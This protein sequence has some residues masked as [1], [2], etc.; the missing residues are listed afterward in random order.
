MC[1]TNILTNCSRKIVGFEYY[2]T[3]NLYL[4][5][6]AEQYNQIL[7]NISEKKNDPDKFA[8]QGTKRKAKNNLYRGVNFVNQAHLE[9]DQLNDNE[10]DEIFN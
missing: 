8:S 3:Q 1:I 4:G 5:E 2:I 6:C 10:P 7:R 9:E